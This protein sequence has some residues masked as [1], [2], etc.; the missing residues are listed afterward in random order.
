MSEEQKL[1]KYGEDE[2]TISINDD[3]ANK[4]EDWHRDWR[5]KVVVGGK[6]YY[7]DLRDK[8]VGWKAGKL[9]LAP[10]DKQPAAKPAA[11]AAAPAQAAQASAPA[12]A[13]QA[14]DD[15]EIPF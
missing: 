11:Q 3:S 7:V 9:K 1:V 12:P 4:Q 5:G 6:L 15:D 10:A 14:N 13:A 8:D 2:L